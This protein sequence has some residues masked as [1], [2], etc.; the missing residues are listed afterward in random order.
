MRMRGFKKTVVNKYVAKG[1]E[2]LAK[3]SIDL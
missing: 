3:G 1:G 2:L